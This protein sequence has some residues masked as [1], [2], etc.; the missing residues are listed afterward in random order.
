LEKNSEEDVPH[1]YTIKEELAQLFSEF[2]ELK[3]RLASNSYFD[4]RGKR[5][6]RKYFNVEAAK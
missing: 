1:H 4:E 6:I 5:Y 2:R 3:I